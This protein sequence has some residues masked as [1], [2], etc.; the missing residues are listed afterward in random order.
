MIFNRQWPV[1]F[2]ENYTLQ[3]ESWSIFLQKR[4]LISE[5]RLILIDPSSIL[6][7]TCWKLQRVYV[8]F[9]PLVLG[10]EVLVMNVCH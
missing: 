8:W 10:D 6:D 2:L 1:S 3:I 9:I 5:K 4:H 7:S